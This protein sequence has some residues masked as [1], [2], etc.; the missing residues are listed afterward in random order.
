MEI[1][2]YSGFSLVGSGGNAHVYRATREGSGGNVVAVK[3]LRGG[4]DPAVTRRFERE[5]N[6]MASLEQLDHVAPILES[7]TTA[8]GDPFLVMP[9][10]E[11]GSL[12]ER[13]SSGPVPWREALRLVRKVA[14]AVTQA[15]SRR[16]L[17]LDIKP[18]NV[19]LDTSG[20]PFLADFGIAEAMGTTASMSAQMFTPAYTAPER[21]DGAKPS[22]QTDV[23]GLGGL[24]YA[25]LTGEAPFVLDAGM[26][27]AAMIMAVLKDDVS[28]EPL[29]ARSPEVVVDLVSNT[30]SKVVEQRPQTAAELCGLIDEILAD[31]SLPAFDPV[32]PFRVGNASESEKPGSE[33]AD[34]APEG[35]VVGDPGTPIGT[36]A[37]VAGEG[38][39]FG[40]ATPLPVPKTAGADRMLTAWVAAAAIFVC[41]VIA[42]ALTGT[43]LNNGLSLESA[44]GESQSLDEISDDGLA[45]PNSA[46]DATSSL[47]T[48]GSEGAESGEE[49]ASAA[50]LGASV[51]AESVNGGTENGD[52]DGGV[53]L[54][55]RDDD[56]GTDDAGNGPIEGERAGDTDE[57]PEQ[58]PVVTPRVNNDAT[59]VGDDPPL[60]ADSAPRLFDDTPGLFVDAPV[61]GP[62]TTSVA[63]TTTEP[64]T[65]TTTTET[66]TT[67]ATE[68]PT[69]TTTTT[70]AP[71][72]STTTTA[73]PTTTTT[74]A[75][76]TT[77]TTAAP[78]TTTT[79]AAPISPLPLEF[80]AR[81]DI[82]DI[83]E[84]SVSFRFTTSADSDYV[85]TIRS[86]GTVAAT[87]GGSASGGVLENV[88]ISGLTAGTDYTVQVTIAGDVPV[89]SAQVPFRTAGGDPEGSEQQ[90]AIENL[91]LVTVDSTRFEVHYET[92][93]CANGSFVIRQLDGP[94]VGSNAGQPDG[95]TT[96]HLGIPGFWTPALSPNTIYVVTFTAE[97]N[98]QGQGGGN[99]TSEDFIVTTA[100]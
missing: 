95:C 54:V 17:H 39:V 21:L 79:T 9:L 16:I 37:P 46:N 47:L 81:I 93:I 50:V 7:G 13:I 98:G 78:T 91:R 88:T 40:Y 20:E 90:V 76:T 49:S 26:T 62:T 83:G 86:G 80:E 23:Y 100:G 42:G 71:S 56:A 4:G 66:P 51:E 55:A 5:R 84:N 75:P 48:R 15:H 6:A 77:T 68:A 92:N 29:A 22:E 8:S 32:L 82:A 96:R 44:S 12:Q 59:R 18:A 70:E 28:T 61:A 24:T 72:T 35:E 85:V 27:P 43:L 53:A 3:V 2:G 60:E 52:D 25:L 19:L 57:P 10:F 64:P 87:Q 38:E 67:T 94:V 45:T 65:T 1:D 30:L 73:A 31:R 99:V 63:P 69:T 41:V 97:A 89:S 34:A 58:T 74:A 36:D 33:G 14:H 11:G